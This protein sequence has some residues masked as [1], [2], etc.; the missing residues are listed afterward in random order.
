MRASGTFRHPD[1]E[2][3]WQ[4]RS[5]IYRPERIYS[6]LYILAAASMLVATGGYLF[7]L[8]QIE[9][10]SRLAMI[11]ALVLFPTLLFAVILTAVRLHRTL[12]P[13]A[14]LN[15]SIE[16]VRSGETDVHIN[17]GSRG[18]MGEL[19][20]GISAIVARLAGGQEE[21]RKRVEQAV[22]DA[23]ESME[24]VEIRNAELLVDVLDVR[25][26]D[27]GEPQHVEAAEPGV[28]E[29]LHAASNV[30]RRPR[31]SRPRNTGEPR[32]GRSARRSIRCLGW[33]R[34]SRRCN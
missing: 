30:A 21:L 12:R 4:G 22:R 11:G 19:E 10:E 15:R 28:C 27:I 14:A 1:S 33:R 24:V 17:A 5:G 25:L 6:W 8:W 18:E 9:G 16:R 20:A 7:Y 31:Y 3:D 34:R 2:T 23:Q 26:R 32:G 13:L 29:R